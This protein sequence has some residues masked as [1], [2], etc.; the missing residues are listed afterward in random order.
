MATIAEQLKEN[1]ERLGLSKAD[2][3]RA[4]GL[5]I[6]LISK[7]EKGHHVNPTVYVIR[8]LSKALNNYKFE[9]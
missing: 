6:D 7:I 4:T 5:S 2:L 8:E 9:I 3:K 1:R